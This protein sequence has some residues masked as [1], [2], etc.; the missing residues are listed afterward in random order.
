MKE[1]LRNEVEQSPIRVARTIRRRSVWYALLLLAVAGSAVDAATLPSGI[2]KDMRVGY[3]AIASGRFGGSL[4]LVDSAERVVAP[5]PEV[6]TIAATGER[7]AEAQPVSVHSVSTASTFVI[8]SNPVR[9]P[10]SI[11]FTLPRSG[12]TTLTLLNAEG[13][14]V[15]TLLE[16]DL[17]SGKH[18][19]EWNATGVAEGVYI[20]MLRNDGYMETDVVEV[21][22][23]RSRSRGVGA[24][25]R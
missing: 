4:N 24:F 19:I 10:T 3:E 6:R 1:E 25:G 17:T 23:V 8:G 16:K 20:L 9:G 12:Q 14:T 2:A 22:P 5:D 7:G 13:T 18:S 11:S 21:V 15:A